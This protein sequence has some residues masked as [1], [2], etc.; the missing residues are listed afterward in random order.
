MNRKHKFS[1]K[2]AETFKN[3]LILLQDS[4]F[5]DAMAAVKNIFAEN[6]AGSF[7]LE[8]ADTWISIAAILENGA[9]FIYGKKIKTELLIC[10]NKPEKALAELNDIVNMGINDEDTDYLSDLLK[11]HS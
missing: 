1:V 3:I 9:D 6:S 7:S 11:N 2:C 8:L 5:T 4:L 10:K